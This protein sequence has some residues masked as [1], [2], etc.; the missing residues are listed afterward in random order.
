M[1][2]VILSTLKRVPFKLSSVFCY[3]KRNA[4]SRA[5]AYH[6]KINNLVRRIGSFTT[7]VVLMLCREIVDPDDL[8]VE[9]IDATSVDILNSVGISSIS[10][11][12]I[13]FAIWQ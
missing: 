3:N 1:H 9:L 5:A 8:S 4:D 7:Q 2:V 11:M 13:I 6:K 12:C 10:M